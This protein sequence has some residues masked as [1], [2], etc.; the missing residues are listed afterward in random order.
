MKANNGD[1]L[2]RGRLGNAAPASAQAAASAQNTEKSASHAHKRDLQRITDIDE[3]QS[4][5]NRT[6]QNGGN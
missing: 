2:G 1:A 3:N 4:I 6:G 5:L